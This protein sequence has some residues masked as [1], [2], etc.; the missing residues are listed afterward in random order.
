MEARPEDVAKALAMAARFRVADVAR[1]FDVSPC[2][3][4]RWRRLHG[5]DRAAS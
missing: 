4:R 2:T 1:A 3:L 5:P